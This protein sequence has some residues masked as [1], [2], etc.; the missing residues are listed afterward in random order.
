MHEFYAYLR[1]NILMGFY[2]GCGRFVSHVTHINEFYARLGINICMATY[3]GNG[4]GS[5]EWI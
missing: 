1:M 3:S 2:F 5:C 4:R